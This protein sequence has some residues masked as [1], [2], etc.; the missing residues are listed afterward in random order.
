MVD[1]QRFL[2]AF[3]GQWQHDLTCTQ[4][5]LLDAFQD[6]KKTTAYMLEGYDPFLKRVGNR[7]NLSTK[8]EWFNLDA[9]YYEAQTDLFPDWG[10]IYPARLEVY[11]EHENGNYPEEEMYKLLM[12]RASLKVLIFYDWAEFQK[13]GNRREHRW[14][15]L[16]EK[17]TT[18]FNMGRAVEPQPEAANA[19]YLLLVGHTTEQGEAPVWRYWHIVGGQWPTAPGDG[20]RLS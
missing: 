12:W 7:L 16:S 9:I 1:A 17:L 14:Q 18:M 20:T 19:E 8:T 2:K 3:I 6:D 13:E 11:I 5:A 10:K 4:Q 15:W